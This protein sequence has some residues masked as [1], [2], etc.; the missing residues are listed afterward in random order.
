MTISTDIII[1][2]TH[3]SGNS[4]FIEKSMANILVI[5]DD[6]IFNELMQAQITKL[7]YDCD[8]AESL[9][10]GLSSA[11]NTP[12]DI[13]FLDVTLPD[14]NG[15]AKIQDF[16]KFK[17]SPEIVIITGQGDP[18][19]AELAI[20]NGAWD[21]IQKPTSLNTVHLTISRALQ[22]R[23]NKSRSGPKQAI[24][25]NGIIGNSQPLMLCLE[26]L[27]Q[28]SQGK[29]NVLITGE[30]GTGKEL[31]ARAVHMN[32]TRAKNQL[33][34]ADCTS[35]PETLAES[36]LFGH[37]KGSFTGANARTLGLFMQADG[38]T[39]FL[40]EIGDLSLPVQKSF[41]RVLQ[42]RKVK[43]I[44]GKNEMPCDFRLV[45]ATNRN[46]E[47]MVTK[48]TFRKDLYYRL[49]TSN[50]NLPPLRDRKDDVLPLLD[51]YLP[52][53]CK[54]L[55]TD[56]KSYSQDFLEAL[57]N[58]NWP[59]NIRE[60]INAINTSCSKAMNEDELFIHHLPTDIRAYLAKIKLSAFDRK[61][62]NKLEEQQTVETLIR[63]KKNPQ[64]DY[65]TYKEARR[66]IVDNME[67]V[68]F[69]D[70]LAHTKKDI[71]KAIQVS[72]LS[73]ARLYELLKKHSISLKNY[74]LSN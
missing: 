34:V 24:V 14:G 12:Y 20:K 67:K 62:A 17:S 73:R 7:G 64:G 65:P 6:L 36:L 39:L 9:Y 13:I 38:G 23:I 69:D 4:K 61:K 21:Y 55:N 5:D 8:T 63:I 2:S 10:Y 68:Y 29:N 71:S 15:L 16:K 70:L 44:G 19:G 51:Y 28:V 57:I 11:E 25:R 18:E 32:S 59:G 37:L 56:L 35:I 49:S 72:G 30:T 60:L 66:R 47:K 1:D 46:L 26:H 33:I 43:P 41:L 52:I 50:I 58:Y 31:F 27:V 54:E 45:S 48:G 74:N 53:S 22:F 3:R 40:D 42:E